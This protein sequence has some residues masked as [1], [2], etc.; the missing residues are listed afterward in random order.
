ME[1]VGQPVSE[2]DRK[3]LTVQKVLEGSGFLIEFLL[4]VVN[5]IDN[6]CQ[7]ISYA[8]NNTE[9]FPPE[10]LFDR[11]ESF[12]MFNFSVRILT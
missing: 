8:I 6:F 10:M 11:T 7:K 5:T 1:I 3:Y 4:N 12:G 9:H 2:A